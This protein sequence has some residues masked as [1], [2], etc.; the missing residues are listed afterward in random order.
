MS[1][2]VLN[3]IGL[4]LTWAIW[5]WLATRTFS[6]TTDALIAIGGT[7]LVIPAVLWGRRQLDGE[8]TVA[9]AVRVTA[10]VHYM[11]A[12]LVGAAILSAVRLAQ[13]W[14]MGTIPLPPW[15]GL[16]IM[17]VSGIVLVLVVFNLALKGLG[18]PFA[19][20]LTRTVATDWFYA[21]TRNPMVLSGLAFLVGLG[22]WLQS[23]LFILWVLII[24]SPALL[25]FLR[26][27]EARELEIRFGEN[28][29]NYKN[30]TPMFF[31][32]RPI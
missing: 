22:L 27:Y 14:A 12:V 19:I 29:L 11:I 2:T 30:N 21:W 31:P 16:G 3:L 6:P 28:Y 7:L 10:G 18:A 8:P 25:I 26:V 24:L 23:T 1:V 17:A 5:G 9:R 15:L 13:N 20:A 4:V 32:N